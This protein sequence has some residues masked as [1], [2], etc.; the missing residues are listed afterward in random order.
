MLEW[1]NHLKV[2]NASWNQ[3]ALKSAT[4]ITAGLR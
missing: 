1:N 4:A 3:F 2:L